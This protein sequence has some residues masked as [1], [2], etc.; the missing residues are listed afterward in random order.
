MVTPQTNITLEE[1]ARLLPAFHSYAICGH[2]NPDG[3]CIGSQLALA[4]ALCL[5]GKEVVCLLAAPD[6]VPHN[7]GFLP[8]VQD[9]V[10]GESCDF[11]PECFVGVDVP[12]AERLGGAKQVLDKTQVSFTID[13]HASESTYAKHV[14]VDPSSPSASMLVWKLIELMGAQNAD[15]AL[16]VMTGLI[17]DT[18]RFANQNTTPE[19]LRV[20]ADLMDRGANPSAISREIFQSRRLASLKLEGVMLA[21][22]NIEEDGAFAWSYLTNE[23]FVSCDAVKADSE[24]FVGTLRSIEGVRVALILKENDEGTVRGSLRA[25]DD[26]NVALVAESYGGG[27][28]KAAAGFTFEG[29]LD[30]AL[31]QVPARVREFCFG[32]EA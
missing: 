4:H 6:S 20:A 32:K 26:T 18:G 22:M 2:V 30:D 17:T 24:P 16:C 7:L 9:L 10:A 12:T 31:A 28:H 15:S 23:D 8:G 29:S 27:G 5:M 3:D 14:Y 19:S 11:V 25:K 13:H 21:H 1:A